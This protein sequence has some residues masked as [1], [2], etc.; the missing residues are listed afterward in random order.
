MCNKLILGDNLEVMKSMPF[1]SVDLIYL[2][3]PF[4]SNRNY[5]VIWGD[6]GEIRSFEDRWAGGIE[7][8]IFWLK[9]RVRQMHRL[10]KPTGSLYLHCDW[11][12]DAYIRVQILDD[13]FGVKNFLSAID[14]CYEDIG[15]KATNYFKRKKDTIFFYSKS[16][17][18]RR[19][20]NL[21]YKPLSESTMT[22]Y[23]SYFDEKGQIT[24]QKLKEVS[25][26]AFAK[27]K[28]IPEDLNKVWLDK[29]K[30]QPLG[31]WWID[32]TAI[33][34]GF[35]EAIGYPTQKPEALLERIIK[36]SS[37][38]GDVVLDPFVGGGTTIVVADALNRKWI[39]IDQSVQAVKVSE[40][41][42]LKVRSAYGNSI[43]N[44]YILKLHK[45]DIDDLTG[46]NAFEFERW[47]ITQ[48]DGEANIK[49]RSDGGIDGKTK[50]NTP[51]QVKQSKNIGRNV[52]D[53]FKSATSRAD[54]QLFEKNIKEGKPV[55]YIIA[56]SFSK[57]AVE[58]VA[59]LRNTENIIIKLVRVDEIIEVSNKPKLVLDF[60]EKG[61]DTNSDV[62]VQISASAKSDAGIEFYSWD[63]SYNEEG[64][65]NAELMLE[66]TGKIERAFAPGEYHIACKVVD[67]DG[68]ENIEIVK[69]RVNGFVLRV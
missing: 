57:G 50:D 19:V 7:N 8:Y 11:H 59:R 56:F 35:T 26:G 13:I 30:G 49:Q 16:N 25:P 3:P 52:I 37:N 20:F 34:K 43:V 22:R 36:A 2:D 4:F 48:F 69:L 62:V 1:E 68:L 6:K 42:F 29:T 51:I 10:L 9:E 27:L 21:Q 23:G 58:E 60:T 65:F 40:M 47:I 63:F 12:A 39:G 17:S 66:P 18:K 41:R 31:D 61:R 33:R 38:E 45:Y 32:I 44:S 24:Y 15:G 46:M 67:A 5:E 28:G 64:G 55:G 14:W 53:N 54:K